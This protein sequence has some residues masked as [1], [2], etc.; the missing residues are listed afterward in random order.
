LRIEID[1][2]KG[3]FNNWSQHG[4]DDEEDD[5]AQKDR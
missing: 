3:A 5:E 2:I 4:Q 1:V